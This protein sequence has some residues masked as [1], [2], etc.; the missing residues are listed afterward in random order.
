T[1]SDVYGVYQQFD[2]PTIN[3][4][5]FDVLIADETGNQAR[6]NYE[7]SHDLAAGQ[8]AVENNAFSYIHIAAIN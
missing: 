6:M 3:Y 7:I 2:D 8:Y 1:I 4:F 5:V